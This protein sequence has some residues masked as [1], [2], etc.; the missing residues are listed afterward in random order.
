VCSS[1]GSK[2]KDIYKDTG[3]QHRGL[4]VDQQKKLRLRGNGEKQTSSKSGKR[5]S[6]ETQR[7]AQ[8]TRLLHVKLATSVK[9][10][11]KGETKI[12]EGGGRKKTS[13]RGWHVVIA[14][15]ER[16]RI[17]RPEKRGRRKAT[18]IAQEPTYREERG[19][20][21]CGRKR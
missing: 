20:K 11:R 7:D 19:Q 3:M 9:S 5:K 12:P 13:K 18:F 17:G 4:T 16:E 2:K 15:M 1:E 6:S 21:T 8:S 14:A 10:G